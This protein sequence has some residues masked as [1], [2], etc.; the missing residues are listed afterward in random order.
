MYSILKFSVS[1]LDL[2]YRAATKNSYNTIQNFLKKMQEQMGVSI[3]GFAAYRNNEGKLRVFELVFI[4]S[5]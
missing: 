5:V 3:I 2:D 1:E 4:I